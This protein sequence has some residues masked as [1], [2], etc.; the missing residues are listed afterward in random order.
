MYRIAAICKPHVFLDHVSS[1]WT[2]LKSIRT[3]CTPP[4]R[5]FFLESNYVD[6]MSFLGWN[7]AACEVVDAAASACNKSGKISKNSSK[8]GGLNKEKKNAGK[9]RLVALM[10]S[11][12]VLWAAVFVVGGVLSYSVY[13]NS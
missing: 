11:E 9:A 3:K 7:G 5:S 1:D 13:A 4:D 12:P 8:S 6:A 2:L 10:S